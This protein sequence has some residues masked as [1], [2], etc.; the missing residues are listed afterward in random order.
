MK[1]H[2]AVG[3]WVQIKQ[4]VL[5][6]GERAPQVPE[7]TKHTPLLLWV[8]GFAIHEAVVGEPISIKTVTGRELIGELVAIEPGYQYGFGKCVPELLAV[9]NQL[10]N[11]MRGEQ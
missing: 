10:R 7:D 3:D 1:T 2:A 5:T 6:V 11:L 8:K 4:V 9:D